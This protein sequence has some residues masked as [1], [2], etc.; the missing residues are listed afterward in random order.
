MFRLE[1]TYDETVA[2]VESALREAG[3]TVAH[4]DGRIV[5]GVTGFTATGEVVVD[6]GAPD[7]SEPLTFVSATG[8]YERR[9]QLQFFLRR[10]GPSATERFE[11]ELRERAGA[12]LTTL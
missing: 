4:E 2:V 6:V 5:G 8:R 11:H 1:R 12:D 9:S 3:T 10:K 7:P